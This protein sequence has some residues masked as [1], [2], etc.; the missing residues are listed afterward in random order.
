[1]SWNGSGPT[2]ALWSGNGKI[3]PPTSN[4]EYLNVRFLS[5]TLTTASTINAINVNAININSSDVNTNT[6][7]TFQ[8][9]LSS[10]TILTGGNGSL[11]I[12]GILVTDASNASN[13]SQWADF[14]AITNINANNKNIINLTSLFGSNLFAS[15]IYN[16][17]NFW[18]SNINTST[19][20]VRG[21]FIGSNITA[22]NILIRNN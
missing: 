16:S 19:L 22:S 10:N 6:L 3:Q 21:Q 15:N 11:Y 8:V 7:S 12:N 1:M 9:H 2:S 4:Y 14:P 13:V 17:R 18:G 20:N 5:T